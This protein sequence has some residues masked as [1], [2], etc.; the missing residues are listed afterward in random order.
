MILGIADR[1][2]ASGAPTFLHGNALRGGVKPGDAPNAFHQRLPMMRPRPADQR[3]INVE[4]NQ[5]A[6]GHQEMQS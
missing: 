2:R 3:A 1:M 4:E 5:S 6:V